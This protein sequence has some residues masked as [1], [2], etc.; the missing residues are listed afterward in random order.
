MALYKRT[1]ITEQP[2]LPVLGGFFKIR[3]PF[4]HYNWSW[5][6]ALQGAVL[7]AT[8][9]AAIPVL[10]IIGVSM[11]V[12]VLMVFI[13]SC[14]YLLHA[15]LGDPIV[16]G[17]IT[18]GIPLVLLYLEAIPMEERTYALIAAQLMIGVVF[19]LLGSTGLAGKFIAWLPN[20]IKGGII[21][22][23][24][25]AAIIGEFSVGGRFMERPYATAAAII[26][27][28]FIL[29]SKK[30]QLLRKES[31]FFAKIVTF[32][33]VPGIV[34]AAVVG[35]LTGEVVWDPISWGFAFSFMDLKLLISN[36]TIFGIGFPAWRYF[37]M[38]A[39]LVVAL[40]IIAYGDIVTGAGILKEADDVR[41]DEVIEVNAN[42]INFLCGVRNVGLALIAPYATFHGP[43]W[44]G[45]HVATVERY[46][47]G[48]E[49]M[50]SIFDGAGSFYIAA[51]IVLCLAPFVG[52]LKPLL[53]IALTLTMVMQGWVCTYISVNM[54]KTNQELGMMGVMGAIL[55]VRGAAWGLA[56]GVILFLFLHLGKGKVVVPGESI[57][58]NKTNTPQ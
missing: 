28:F 45:A 46:K 34:V 43:I 35:T 1:E 22:G 50:D 51:T 30:G 6:D 18:P 24:G 58:K 42:R 19:L 49:H 16:P 2:H 56:A 48:R 14:F 40:Y 57:M 39:G 5:A 17:W 27:A 23:A 9:L 36:Y 4:I 31:R 55:A 37:V 7:A 13:S 38:A 53:P 12:A 20:V 54:A 47:L 32:G 29:Y 11:E 52:V 33:I 21:L 3:I 25:F 10:Q 8:G 26:I 15:F 44:G 41:K